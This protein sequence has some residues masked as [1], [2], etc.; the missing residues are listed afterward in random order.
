MK[1]FVQRRKTTG[2]AIE[3]TSNGSMC[4]AFFVQE[5]DESLL[6]SVTSVVIRSSLSP[7]P[8]KMIVGKNLTLH[9]AVL[10]SL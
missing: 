9:N 6:A 7:F 5:I 2:E 3:T 4:T 1:E 8:K 10:S